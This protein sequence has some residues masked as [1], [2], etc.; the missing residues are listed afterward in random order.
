MNLLWMYVNGAERVTGSIPV[1][2]WYVL[3]ARYYL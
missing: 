2:A 1:R 3:V